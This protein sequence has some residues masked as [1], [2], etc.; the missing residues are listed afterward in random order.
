M[1][2]LFWRVGS[3]ENVMPNQC[4][5]P[6]IRVLLADVPTIL[7]RVF[8]LQIEQQAD[9]Q[10]IGDAHGPVDILQA[11]VEADLVIIS[12]PQIDPPPGI[13]S[14]LLA[15]YPELKILVLAD[16]QDVAMGYWLDIQRR[17]I[18]SPTVENLVA[19]IR[20]LFNAASKPG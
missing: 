12:A 14:H 5:S 2:E 15:E 9:I 6:H 8:M 10:I 16:H 3:I 1:P 13:C 4:G 17:R 11:A 20:S 18:E 19:G 7:A